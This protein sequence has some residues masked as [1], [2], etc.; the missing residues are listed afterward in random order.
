[1]KFNEN[2]SELWFTLKHS[3]IIVLDTQEW[4]VTKN[5]SCKT[6]VISFTKAIMSKSTRNSHWIC[7]S[8]TDGLVILSEN[9]NNDTIEVNSNI[10][11]WKSIRQLSLSF[12]GKQL[13]FI[14]KSDGSLKLYALDTLLHQTFQPYKLS[15][16][17]VYVQLN[18]NL[19]LFDKKV[20]N[21]FGK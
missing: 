2:G 8:K 9:T 5:V 12:D 6:S 20:S 10:T 14:D 19:G 11:P 16:N 18:K 1:M 17:G 13:A 15:E 21:A 3:H 7:I 4:Q